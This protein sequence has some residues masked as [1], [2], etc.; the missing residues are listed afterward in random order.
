MNDEAGL[1]G[2]DSVTWRVHVEQIMWIAGL[3]ALYLQSLHPRVMRGTYQNSALFDRA[4]AW[5][6]FLRTAEFVTVRTYG[7]SGGVEAAAARV[8]DIHARLRAR[9]P[10]TGATF[11]LDEPDA[12]LW[13]HCAEIDSYVDV[14]HRSGILDD[15][16]ADAYVAESRRAGA[17]VGVDPE[18]APASRADLDAYF[19]K[20]R[21]RLR[22]TVEAARGLLNSFHPPL[23]T[24]LAPLRLAVPAAN[25]LALSSLPAWARRVF[26]APNLPGTHTVVTLQ[27]KALRAAS[28]VVQPPLEVRI[29]RARLF[30]SEI[31]ARR[32]SETSSAGRTR[33]EIPRTSP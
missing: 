21:P 20:V 30:A 19:Q 14:A 8:R 31:S 3:R 11:R 27:L 4:R 28:A 25:L 32:S 2:P 12:L 16:G 22:L 15:A 5:D 7:A 23:P 17:A 24:R 6:R 9:D 1:F 13:V 10:D 18:A 33:S 29:G 26:G